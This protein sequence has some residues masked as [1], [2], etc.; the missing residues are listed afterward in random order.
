MATQDAID[1]YRAA[2]RPAH[3]EIQAEMAAYAEEHGF[4]H[5]GPDAGSV[6]R[7]LARATDA[8]RVFEFGSG[9]GYS[10]TWFLAGMPPDGEI[11]LTEADADE[12][13][14]GRDFLERAG[15]A[16]RC[17]FELGD[18]HDAVDRHDGPFDVVLVDH[19]KAEY[20][21]AF[22]AV[23]PK[24]PVGGVV[25]ADNVMRDPVIAYFADDTPMPDDRRARGLVEYLQRVRD[26]PAFH[27]VVLP[28]GNGLA[29]ST[30]EDA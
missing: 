23:R 8:T 1:R 11:V 28:V 4:P 17:H 12:L 20:P 21:A 27:T 25:A 10:A 18:A 30:R 5:I 2:I 19:T 7:S 24:V 22:D 6:L 26:D 16:D 14:L 9:F 15:L 3:D 29:V 13:D